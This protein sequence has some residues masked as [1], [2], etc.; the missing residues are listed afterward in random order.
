MQVLAVAVLATTSGL[1]NAQQTTPGPRQD[2][3]YYHGHGMMWG[4]HMGGFGLFFGPLFLIILVVAIAAA[5]VILM[6]TFGT[7][8][9]SNQ[10]AGLERSEGNALDILKERFAKGEIDADEFNERKRLLS[11]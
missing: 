2:Y 1:A 4:D 5:V 9:A 10:P 7:T 8:G 11:E 6:R 3:P